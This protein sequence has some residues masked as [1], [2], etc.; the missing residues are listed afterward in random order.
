VLVLVLK[1]SR[2]D[3]DRLVEQRPQSGRG[4]LVKVGLVERKV[5]SNFDALDV[6]GVGPRGVLLE[7][8]DKLAVHTERTGHD[9]HDVLRERAWFVS[10]DD[11]FVETWATHQSCRCR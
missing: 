11:D 4:N 2:V 1:G 10:A 3:A 7:L 9:G 8:V 5:V 6:V